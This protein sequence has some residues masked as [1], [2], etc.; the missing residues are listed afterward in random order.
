[1]TELDLH[2]KRHE[3]A[4]KLLERAIN[5]MWGSEEDLHIITGH[6][7]KMKQL[8][9]DILKEYKLEYTIGDF[10]GVNMGYIR[11]HLD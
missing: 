6:S 8:V 5:S 11:T 10:T 7:S 3:E 2:G 4:G 9:I 1:M